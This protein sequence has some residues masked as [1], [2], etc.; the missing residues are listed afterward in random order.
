MPRW[1][2]QLPGETD[3]AIFFLVTH[4]SRS[5][6]KIKLFAPFTHVIRALGHIILLAI[7]PPALPA[8]NAISRSPNRTR[9][10][11]GVLI[12]TF[13]CCFVLNAV[14]AYLSGTLTGPDTARLYFSADRWNQTL[15][16]LVVPIYSAAATCLCVTFFFKWNELNAIADITGPADTQY[17]KLFFCFRIFGFLT[18]LLL[19]SATF[20]AAFAADLFNNSVVK[21]IYWFFDVANDGIRRLNKAGYYYVGLNLVLLEL[22]FLALVSYVA[23]SMEV[24][25]IGR[26]F[27]TPLTVKTYGFKKIKKMMSSYSDCY[28]FAKLLTSTYIA[29]IYIWKFSPLGGMRNVTVAALV[30]AFIGIVLIDIP[31]LYFSLKWFEASQNNTDNVDDAW[32]D[33]RTNEQKLLGNGF[34]AFLAGNFLVEFFQSDFKIEH[35]FDIFK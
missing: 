34:D 14:L 16:I 25:R 21:Q 5:L 22:T 15:Y 12:A 27:I 24:I 17:S 19:T 13:M 30:L 1:S 32:K 23:M 26:D 29:N 20:I 8:R 28:V 2:K 18:L 10:A 6:Q 31:R 9:I 33:L 4:L 3:L 11:I 35:L 7:L